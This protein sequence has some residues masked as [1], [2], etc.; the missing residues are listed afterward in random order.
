MIGRL[1]VCGD[2]VI[3][4]SSPNIPPVEHDAE[5]TQVDIFQ[6]DGGGEDAE[7]FLLQVELHLLKLV[8]QGSQICGNIPRIRDLHRRECFG[9]LVTKPV[10]PASKAS[11]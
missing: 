11:R 4:G 6:L 9:K 3:A 7:L 5:R 1:R 10:E 8:F 2:Y